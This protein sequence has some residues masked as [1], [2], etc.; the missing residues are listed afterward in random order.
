MTA[1]E[2]RPPPRVLVQSPEPPYDVLLT[3]G[4]RE[5]QNQG[6]TG[7]TVPV[8]EPRGGPD[9]DVEEETITLSLEEY[10]R[11][12]KPVHLIITRDAEEARRTEIPGTARCG[13]SLPPQPL[14]PMVLVEAWCKA[15]FRADGIA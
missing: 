7:T 4:R 10:R 3:V 15:C 5:I 9:V 12:A 6:P 8:T 11:L 2:R 14:L 1:T 13:V